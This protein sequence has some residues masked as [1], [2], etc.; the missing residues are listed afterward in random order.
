MVARDPNDS[1]PWETYPDFRDGGGYY[2]YFWWGRMFGADDYSFEA[3]A[4]FSPARITES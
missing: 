2:K 4:S 1:H 3:Q